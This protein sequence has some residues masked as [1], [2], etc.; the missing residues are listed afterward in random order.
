MPAPARAIA[1]SLVVA[2]SPAV[3]PALPGGPALAAS[4]RLPAAFDA[5]FAAFRKAVLSGDKARV[6]SMVGLP[7]RDYAGGEVDRSATTRAQFL[8]HYDAIFTP[9]VIAA[10]RANRTRGFVPGGDDGEAPGPLDKGE[11]L[12][13]APNFADQLVFTPKDGTYVLSRIPFYS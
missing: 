1:L 13:D 6:A 7:F 11:F 10:I 12:L 4:A 3:G 9:G 8:A 5:F 2:V